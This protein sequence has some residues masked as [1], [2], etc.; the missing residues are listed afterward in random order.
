MF[1]TAYERGLCACMCVCVRVCVCES[2]V[3]VEGDVSPSTHCGFYKS[4]GSFSRQKNK[5]NKQIKF[6]TDILDPQRT[7][8]ND[9]VDPNF[10]F[11]ATRR[12]KMSLI[13]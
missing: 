6:C 11:S 13:L 1:I 3:R 10:S 9:S 4:A 5:I 8:P 7:N 2:G 12:S